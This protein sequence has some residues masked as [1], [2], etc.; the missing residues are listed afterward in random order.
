MKAPK[1]FEEL[2][3]WIEKNV[4]KKDIEKTPEDA[5]YWFV[6]YQQAFQM[7]ECYRIKDWAHLLLDGCDP[8]KGRPERVTDWLECALDPENEIGED[9]LSHED[10]LLK[11]LKLHFG[12]RE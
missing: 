9:G 12:I 3:T 8:V 5:A 4:P 2:C 11:D 10:R 6:A 7:H 1:T